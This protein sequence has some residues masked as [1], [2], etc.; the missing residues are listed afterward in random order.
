VVDAETLQAL[1]TYRYEIMARYAKVLRRAS[2]AEVAR[3]R[4]EAPAGS[5]WQLLAR[6]RRWLY[7]DGETPITPAEQ[8]V[9]EQALS[10]SAQLQLMVQMRRELAALWERSHNSTEQLIAQ[11]QDWCQRAQQS[12]I[13]AMQDLA[14]RIRS[15]ATPATAT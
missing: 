9:L 11:L 7:R 2:R 1:I 13:A 4:A 6:A 12:G 3:L 14:L 8:Q 15:Y 10:H 5:Q